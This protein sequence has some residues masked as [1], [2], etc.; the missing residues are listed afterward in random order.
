MICVERNGP[1]IV[2]HWVAVALVETP[3]TVRKPCGYLAMPKLVADL[4]AHDATLNS[5]TVDSSE[6]A[7]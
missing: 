4:R 7:A 6:E 2:L 5:T 3:K 1:T